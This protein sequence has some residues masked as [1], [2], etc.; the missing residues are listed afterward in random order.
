MAADA[1]VGVV[2]VVKGIVITLDLFPV[3]EIVVTADTGFRLIHFR[4]VPLMVAFGTSKP[5]D[6]VLVGKL[7]LGFSCFLVLRDTQYDPVRVRNHALV[8]FRHALC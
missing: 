5:H 3:I 8:F 1:A 4:V 2:P 7:N 6:V